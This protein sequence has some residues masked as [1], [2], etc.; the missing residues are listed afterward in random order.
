MFGTPNSLIWGCTFSFPFLAYGTHHASC[1]SPIGVSTISTRTCDPTSF[2]CLKTRASGSPFSVST[3]NEVWVTF[4][5]VFST[6]ARRVIF[7]SGVSSLGFVCL[8]DTF[9]GFIFTPFASTVSSTDKS[10]VYARAATPGQACQTVAS[11]VFP[12]STSFLLITR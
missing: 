4:C 9:R 11:T 5:L 2:S 1:I 10:L 7:D 8:R 6:S 3:R 12:T